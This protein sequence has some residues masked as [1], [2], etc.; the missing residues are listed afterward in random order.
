MHRRAQSTGDTCCQV[1]RVGSIPTPIL[2]LKGV[3]SF[4][5]AHEVGSALPLGL[6][7][8]IPAHPSFVEQMFI[9]G[10]GSQAQLSV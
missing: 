9:K 4:Y 8:P 6:P 10:E 3:K 7:A 5:Q 1:W 2:R